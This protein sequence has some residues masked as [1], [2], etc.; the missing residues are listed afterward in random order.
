MVHPF[1]RLVGRSRRV[2][3]R[4]RMNMRTSLC[5]LYNSEFFQHSEGYM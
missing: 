3:W 5:A 4:G 1:S 2:L